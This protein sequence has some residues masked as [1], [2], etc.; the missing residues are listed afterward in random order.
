VATE[1]EHGGA[2]R[3]SGDLNPNATRVMSRCH[4]SSAAGDLWAT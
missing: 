1:V 3:A 4:I 2:M